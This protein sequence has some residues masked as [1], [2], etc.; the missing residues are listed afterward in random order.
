MTLDQWNAVMAVN[1]TGYF[2]T[3]REAVRH[4]LKQGHDPKISKAAGKIIFISSVHQ[5]IPRPKGAYFKTLSSTV[6]QTIFVRYLTV[7]SIRGTN[8]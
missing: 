6:R 7:P 2:L 1:L 3:A 8:C 5:I 4:F